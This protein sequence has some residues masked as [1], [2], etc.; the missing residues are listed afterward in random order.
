[1]DHVEVAGLDAALNLV[2]RVAQSPEL[3]VRH[4]SL[5]PIGQLRDRKVT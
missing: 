3:P 2:A 4:H 5:L 1:V